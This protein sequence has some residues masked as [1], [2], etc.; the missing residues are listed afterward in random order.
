M[1]G[2][3]TER[4]RMSDTDLDLV[5]LCENPDCRRPV[6]RKGTG[7]RRWTC[8]DR[9]RQAAR[10]ARLRS[11]TAKNADRPNIPDPEKS[12]KILEENQHQNCHE[13]PISENRALLR[14]EPVN[15]KLTD[16]ELIRV[17]A[18]HG[19]WG[20]F[21]ATKAV[22]WA[23]RVWDGPRTWFVRVR[24]ERGDWRFGP[25]SLSRAKAAAEARVNR[26]PF[27]PDTDCGERVGNGP[28]DLNRSAA[29]FIDRDRESDKKDHGAKPAY[30]T[31]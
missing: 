21:N 1:A 10:R 22:A 26:A 23:M 29:H 24:D 30:R 2:R 3:V 27:Q 11:V 15:E 13:T 8:D 4:A 19:K 9:C 25:T 14:W 7:R 20:G 18:C 16:G 17:A 6:L 12:G 31:L 5:R 28:V